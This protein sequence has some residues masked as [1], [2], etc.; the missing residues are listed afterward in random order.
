MPVE[1][2]KK[3]ERVS[4][5]ISLYE[6]FNAKVL[7]DDIYCTKGHHLG[8]RQDGTVGVI[9]LQRGEPLIFTVCQ[10]CSDFERIGEAIPKEERGWK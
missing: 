9:R 10:S 3:G 2:I 4:I 6:C 5:K 7:D 1:Q 8:N